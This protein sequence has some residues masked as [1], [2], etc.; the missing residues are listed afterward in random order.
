MDWELVDAPAETSVAV[1]FGGPACERPPR[2]HRYEVRIIG[3]GL[4]LVLAGNT[5]LRAAGQCFLITEQTATPSF[6]TIRTWVLRLGLYELRRAKPRANDWVFIVDA[7]IAVGQHKALV[8]LGARLDDMRQH[9]F[10]LGHQDV[11]I[12]ELAILTRCDGL[13]VQAQLEAAAQA[14]GVPRAVVS[15][16]GSDVKRG[17]RLFA[18]AHPGVV[19]FYDLTHRL[20]CLL[21]RELGEYWWWPDFLKQAGQ[22]RQACQQTVWSHLMPPAQR[23]KARWFNLE[24]II[25]WALRVVAYGR[26][27]RLE[28]R[29]FAI[30]FGWLTAFEERLREARQLVVMMKAVCVP[31]KAKGINA[32]RVD[33]CARR[34]AKIAQTERS[35]AFGRQ[36]IEFLREQAAQ[37]KPGETMLASS[38]VIESLFGK[39]KAIVER[40]PMNA[41]TVMVL[42]VAAIT[43]ERT[44]DVIR[45]AMETVSMADVNGWFEANGEPTLLAKRRAA[46]KDY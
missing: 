32:A 35:R 40:S 33:R 2:G 6:W 24:P 36:I 26:R 21:E 39:Y 15:D 16:G 19:W 34:I 44:P 14:V 7:T 31:I 18:E 1:K 41:M 28:S 43:S 3:M 22:C 8:I 45:E 27:H 10:N 4:N 9:G 30:L 20:A 17:V 12:L 11:A 29:Q 37:V 13:T 46:L 23:T 38:D 42:Q 25:R 5:T